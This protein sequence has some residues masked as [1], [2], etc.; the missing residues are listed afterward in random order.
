METFNNMLIKALQELGAMLPT[1]KEDTTLFHLGLSRDMKERE[2]LLYSPPMLILQQSTILLSILL[3][4]LFL[5]TLEPMKE[6]GSLSMDQ[7]S[8]M[9]HLRSKSPLLVT[10]VLLS[11][12][13]QTKYRL[14][15]CP[16]LLSARMENW[17]LILLL[18]K[19]AS[20]RDLALPMHSTI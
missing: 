1:K 16:L 5:L 8:P 12:L 6:T 9:T 18:R 10:L 11:V 15:F 2:R 19:M 7:G 17:S 20:C 4:L 13:L 3:L 14:M